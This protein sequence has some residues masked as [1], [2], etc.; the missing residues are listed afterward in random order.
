MDEQ[1]NKAPYA[2]AVIM[3]GNRRWAKEQGIPQ[4]E[5][6]RVGLDKVKE[7]LEWCKEVGVKELTLYAFSTENWNRAEAEVK[8]FME[9]VDNALD[10]SFNEAIAEGVCVRFIGIRKML[11]EHIQRK[12]EKLEHE[13]RE[14]KNGTFVLALSYG[15]RAEILSAVNTVLDSGRK[16]VT[17][18]EFK[19]AMWSKGLKDPDL[20]IRTGGDYRLSNFL[21]WQS[22]YSELFFT[23]TKWPA[24]SKEE[25]LSILKEFTERERRHGK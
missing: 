15:G 25:F 13:S 19:E 2:I 20:I 8:Y 1:T 23:N 7:L 4:M 11:P 9:L 17:E 18:E 10:N 3:D 14:G 16:Q 12:M 5:G 6:H 21:T 24:F 22:V